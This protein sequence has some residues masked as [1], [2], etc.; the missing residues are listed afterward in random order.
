MKKIAVLL[1]LLSAVAGLS[2]CGKADSPLPAQDGPEKIHEDVSAETVQRVSIG[3]NARSIVIRQSAEDHFSFYNGDLNDAHT[4]QV[5]CEETDGVLTIDIEME[6]GRDDG[7]S[8]LGSL[9]ID[10]P[11][12]EF[13]AVEASGDF[14]QISAD[15]LHSDLF[16]HADNTF[17]N[18]D[19]E[20]DRLEHDI[21]LDGSETGS[22]TGASLYLDRFPDNVKME[23]D[24]AP[25][26][27]INDPDGILVENGSGS[28]TPVISVSGTKE[29]N[30]YRKE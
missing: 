16:V 22:L 15:T 20:A 11:Q 28:G 9:L 2:A 6:T 26:G 14:R 12:Q 1:L 10:I 7:N 24:V 23:L 25:G 21:T 30:I 29:I 19:L 8:I 17:V 3:G 5:R 13:E 18:L 27:V 4:Y